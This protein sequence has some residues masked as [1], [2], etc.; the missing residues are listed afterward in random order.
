[1]AARSRG[2]HRVGLV[3]LLAVSAAAT[4]ARA[5]CPSRAALDAIAQQAWS[6]PAVRPTCVAIHA[7]K[8]LTLV[9]D[10]A[11][12]DLEPPPR[13][14]DAYASGGRGYAAIVDAAGAI[15]W[16]DAW[17]AE[18]PGNVKQWTLVDLD[19]D[20][21]DEL[22]EQHIHIGH[23]GAISSALDVLVIGD[24]GVPVLG[25]ELPLEESFPKNEN[26]CHSTH[27]LV[28]TGRT[29]AIEVT[30]TRDNDPQFPPADD[31]RCPR[32][33]RHRYRWDGKQLSELR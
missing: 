11:T 33:G 18:T 5:G 27:R 28:H 24:D 25:R 9:I 17:D 31:G 7:H 32:Q 21:R 3:V 8:R 2:V 30:G 13:N 12:L 29:V 10:T 26:A 6:A 22:V 19:G 14:F 16:Y 23:M 20:G 15:A 4:S 1:M